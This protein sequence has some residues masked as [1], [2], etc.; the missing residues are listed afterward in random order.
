MLW[1][2]GLAA[3]CLIAAG[4]LALGRLLMPPETALGWRCPACRSTDEEC[5]CDDCGYRRGDDPFE[6]REVASGA[7]FPHPDHWLLEL[8]L[9]NAE[10]V[11]RVCGCTD[12]RACP[13]GCWWIQWDLCS[14]CAQSR[15]EAG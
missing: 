2:L 13:G 12:E 10:R 7:T 8:H 14:A 9:Q 3:L 6:G 11:C 15:K 4:I 5:R 1:M